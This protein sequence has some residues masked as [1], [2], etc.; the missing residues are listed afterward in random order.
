MTLAGGH[1]TLLRVYED[2]GEKTGKWGLATL[3]SPSRVRRRVGF[4]ISEIDATML[5]ELDGMNDEADGDSCGTG[6]GDPGSPEIGSLGDAVAVDFP[7][8][9]DPSR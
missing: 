5:S 6:S 1:V 9:R 7:S 8:S 4:G 3:T 2:A